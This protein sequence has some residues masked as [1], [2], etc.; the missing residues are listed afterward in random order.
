[1][2]IS[3][4]LLAINSIKIIFTL[5]HDNNKITNKNTIAFNELENIAWKYKDDI[6]KTQKKR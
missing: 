3:Y 5:L 2:Y 4:L 1:M 6:S